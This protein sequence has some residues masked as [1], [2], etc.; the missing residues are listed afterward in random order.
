MADDDAYDDQ[1]VEYNDNNANNEQVCLV[2]D[3]EDSF[4]SFVQILLAIMA[5]ASLYIKRQQEVPR[6]RFETWFLDVS[7]Q[8]IGAVYAHVLNMAIAKILANNVR[9]DRTLDD[10]CAWYAINYI[11]DTTLGLVLSILCLQLLDIIAECGHCPLLASRGVYSGP[12]RYCTWLI[13]LTIWCIILTVVKLIICWVMWLTSDVL[14]WF[15]EVL[16]EPFQRNIRF[17]LLFVMIMFPGILNVIYFWIIDSYL[18]ASNHS[19]DS[20]EIAHQQLEEIDAKNEKILPDGGENNNV[21][22]DKIGNDNS[23]QNESYIHPTISDT[24]DTSN[25]IFTK[26]ALV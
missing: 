23:Y 5:L 4:T 6:R 11:I 26:E 1:Y 19:H 22:T 21:N 2:F 12:Y 24:Q 7:K 14:A 25:K 17:E 10:E 16:F 8:G 20:H 15:G 3:A 18:K 13:Q 9:G